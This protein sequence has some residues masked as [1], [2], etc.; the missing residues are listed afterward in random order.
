[1]S[2]VWVDDEGGSRWELEPVQMQPVVVDD[3]SASGWAR[4][5]VREVV[6]TVAAEATRAAF[7][8]LASRMQNRRGGWS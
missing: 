5:L 1:M 8:L 4:E 7:D 6:V 3:G 2:W